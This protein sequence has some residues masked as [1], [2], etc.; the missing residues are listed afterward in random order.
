MLAKMNMK[1][2]FARKTR[3]RSLYRTASICFFIFF[4]KSALSWSSPSLLSEFQLSAT[5]DILFQ[6]PAQKLKN[7]QAQVR[8]V[9]LQIFGPTDHLFEAALNIAGHSDAQEFIFDLHEATIFSSR[10]IPRSRIK[11]GKFFLPIGRLNSIHQHD[12]PFVTA[13]KVIREFFSPGSSITGAEGASDFGI[14]YSL[15]LPTDRFWEVTLGITNGACY[16]H[17]HRFGQ[18]AQVP[19]HFFRSATF[20]STD[21]QNGFLLGFNYLG[22]KDAQSIRTHLMGVDATYKVREAQ[23]LRFLLQN[24]AY[25]Q[26][27]GQQE[28]TKKIGFYSYPQYGF[29]PR[30]S[31]GLRLDGFTQLNMRFMSTGEKRNNFDYAFSPTLTYKPSEFSTFRLAYLHDVTTT[32]GI[33]DQK[34]FSVFLQAIFI[35]GAHPAH[36][37]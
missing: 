24:E 8:S 2:N 32:Q 36:D 10:L 25:Y 30:W 26:V 33:E 19:L 3:S 16:G 22:R 17:C 23:T 20:F 12:W 37:F 34:F 5:G 21:T 4:L 7:S 27:Q 35:L 9:E 6:I 1:L 11:V 29:N 31:L 13:P 28:S 18:P 14:E 15:L